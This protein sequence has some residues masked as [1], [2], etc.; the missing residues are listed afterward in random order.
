M[1]TQI[2]LLAFLIMLSQLVFANDPAYRQAMQSQ[3]KALGAAQSAAEYQAVANGFNRISEMNPNEWLPAYYTAL[4]YTNAGFIIKDDQAA[5]D[6]SFQLAKQ[7][8]EA[9]IQANGENAELVA[10]K[11]YA[12]MGELAVDPQTRGQELSGLVMQTFGRALKLDPQNPRAMVLMAQM[13]LGMSKFFGQGP[14]KAC[15]M[16]QQSLQFFENEKAREN[17]NPFAPSWGE[18]QAQGVIRACQ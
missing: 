2:T 17:A 3:L 10:L 13:Q 12:L 4:A 1:K 7:T 8:I 11:G 14:E 9:S 18:E 6:R 16:A 15:G 5:Q